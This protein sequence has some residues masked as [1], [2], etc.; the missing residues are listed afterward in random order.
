M[1]AKLL[2]LELWSASHLSLL[3]VGMQICF[4][5]CS[6]AY[7]HHFFWACMQLFSFVFTAEHAPCGIYNI[8]LS[9]FW[10]SLYC[11]SC[12]VIIS[13]LNVLPKSKQ[14]ISCV[15]VYW[16]GGILSDNSVGVNHWPWIVAHMWRSYFPFYSE[17]KNVN[18]ISWFQLLADYNTYWQNRIGF[19]RTLYDIN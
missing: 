18:S 15:F 17:R 4:W 11:I 16:Y 13:L 9:P 5:Q 12:F 10:F 6:H 14:M 3:R 19:C 7:M 8:Y 1:I 2:F